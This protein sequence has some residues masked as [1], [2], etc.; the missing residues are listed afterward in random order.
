ME[1]EAKTEYPRLAAL[2]AKI[3]A[4]HLRRASAPAGTAKEAKAG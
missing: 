2:C 3:W 4:D 1:G